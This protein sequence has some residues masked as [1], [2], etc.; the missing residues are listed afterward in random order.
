MPG[1][2]KI[3]MLE[4]DQSDAELAEMILR[5][6]GIMFVSQRVDT[7]D[8]FIASL[9]EFHPDVI[10]ADYHLPAFDGKMALGIATVCAPDIPL[11]FVSGAIGDDLAVELLKIGARDYILKDR[12]AR[13]PSAIRR[14]LAEAEEIRQRHVVEK[15]LRESEEKFRTMTYSAQDA[16]VLVDGDA[17][18]SF[19]N[20]AAERIFGL[21]MREVLGRSLIDLF[22][23]ESFCAS[24]RSFFNRIRGAISGSFA[25]RTVELLAKHHDGAEFPLEAS[26]A[27]LVL[28]DKWHA[29][30][31]ARDISERKRTEKELA[32]YRD[33]LEQRVKSRTDELAHANT[34]LREANRQLA[35]AHTQLLQS[36]RM[37][38]LG[39]LAGG[40]AHEI[41]NPIAFISANLGTLK[42]YFDDL[43]LMMEKVQKGETAF[44]GTGQDALGLH[45]MKADADALVAE[46][47]DGLSRVKEIVQELRE[48][49]SVGTS[50]WR[51]IDLHAG[52]EAAIMLLQWRITN[53]DIVRDYGELPEVQCLPSEINLVFM[54]LLLNASEAITG[55]G[56]I[57]VRTRAEDEGV[58]VEVIDTG[59]GIDKDSLTR[60]FDPF[61]STK[62][63]GQGIGLGLS[64]SYGIVQRHHGRIEVTSTV[65]KGS[66]F[67]VWLPNRREHAAQEIPSPPHPAEAG[68]SPGNRADQQSKQ[69]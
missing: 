50:D 24:Y 42:S 21:S 29:I 28:D 8:T 6:A 40:V 59:R 5:K 27:T 49:A 26:I 63:I 58:W 36:E 53:A 60:V 16:I 44:I 64:L 13:L 15:A 25:G 43:F 20:A 67:R 57:T 34:S 51:C 32:H 7:R 39:Q 65:G 4:D 30:F 10:L 66:V 1:E 12:L 54:N 62:T 23:P 9:E 35:D 56:T 19:W 33:D 3:L 14:A 55:H 41:N 2:L 17:C 47:R 37:A 46:S 61:F 68:C 22:A 38:S 31:I 11:I 18:I 45:E 48:F 69:L 52:L